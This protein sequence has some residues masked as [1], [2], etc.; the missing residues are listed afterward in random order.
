MA[1]LVSTVSGS[2]AVK[3]RRVGDEKEGDERGLADADGD[4]T[5]IASLCAACNDGSGRGRNDGKVDEMSDGFDKGDVIVR[6]L[7]SMEVLDAAGL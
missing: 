2:A 4:S 5:G 3:R 7:P 1:A 6:M